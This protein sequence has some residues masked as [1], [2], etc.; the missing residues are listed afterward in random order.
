MTPTTRV[1]IEEL[2][3]SGHGVGRLATG[4]VVLVTRAAPGETVEATIV[5]ERRNV[6]FARVE[7]VVEPSADRIEPVCGRAT[8]CGGCPWSHLSVPAQRAAKERLLGAELER[9]GLTVA[10]RPALKAGRDLGYRTRTRLHLAGRV[11]GTMAAASN[12]V[13]PFEGCPV[14]SPGLDA[15]AK[16]MTE[17]C[18]ALPQMTAEI[19]LH[20]DALGTRGLCVRIDDPISL[21]TW[22]RAAAKLGA[23]CLSV[24]PRGR[25]RFEPHIQGPWL[26]ETSGDRRISFVPGVFVQASREMNATLVGEVVSA[27][28]GSKSFFEAYAGAGN[29][30]VHLASSSGEGEAAEGDGLAVRALRHNLAPFS[31]VAVH[32]EDDGRTGRRLARGPVHDVALADPPR[33]GLAPLMA[34]L[35]RNPP[36]RV[37]MVSCDPVTAV[38]DMA[39]LVRRAGYEVIRV[40]ALDMFPQTPHLEIVALLARG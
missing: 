33:A 24:L 8:R 40:Q 35:A 4:K 32:E 30:T 36:S 5:S 7:Q 38:R 27:A 11:L 29:F 16:E 15:F 37:V 13:V 31:H 34:G 26:T 18:V 17:T 21:P 6:A 3:F 10:H 39:D 23:T 20:V 9:A 2:A 28:A 25:A 22:Q 19:E 14:L 12:D 1:R